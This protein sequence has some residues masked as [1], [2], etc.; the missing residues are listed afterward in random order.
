MIEI[1]N[2]QNNY[3]HSYLFLMVTHQVM[4]IMNMQ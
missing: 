4:Q 1:Q 3:L 2:Q